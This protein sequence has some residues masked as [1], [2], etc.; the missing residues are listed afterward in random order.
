M[1]EI[2]IVVVLL[3]LGLFAGLSCSTTPYVPTRSATDPV[4]VEHA[5]I[6]SSLR[7]HMLKKEGCP[8]VATT[9]EYSPWLCHYSAKSVKVTGGKPTPSTEDWCARGRGGAEALCE[10]FQCG[11][12]PLCSNDCSCTPAKGSCNHRGRIGPPGI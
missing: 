7:E 8:I 6:V 11:H 4:C 10:E 5:K 12:K 1:K 2:S 3:T 9:T